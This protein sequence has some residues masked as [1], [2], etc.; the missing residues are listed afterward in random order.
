MPD[1]GNDFAGYL[2]IDAAFSTVSGWRSVA[3]A[4]ARRLT[5]PTG[6]LIGKPSYGYDVRILLNAPLNKAFAERKIQEQC[7]AEERVQAASVSITLNRATQQ[8]DIDIKIRTADGPFSMTIDVSQVTTQIF[9]EQ[10][11]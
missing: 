1:F 6:G 5:T 2:D 9:F 8:I 7:L 3:H 4:I 11:A 10:A